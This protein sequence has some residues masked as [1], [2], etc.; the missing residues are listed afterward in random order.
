[1]TEP[2]AIVP[3]YGY[4]SHDKTITV[5]DSENYATLNVF[6][7]FGHLNAVHCRGQYPHPYLSQQYDNDLHFWE[8]ILFTFK[9]PDSINVNVTMSPN[10]HDIC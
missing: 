7:N 8:I 3:S 1:M 4:D 9:P 6:D 5:T 2:D 10:S